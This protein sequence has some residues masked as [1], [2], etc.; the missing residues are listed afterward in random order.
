MAFDTLL[1]VNEPSMLL[2][3][4]KTAFIVGIF[5]AHHS[6]PIVYTTSITVV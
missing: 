4:D 5:N 3:I 2:V 1:F 6:S